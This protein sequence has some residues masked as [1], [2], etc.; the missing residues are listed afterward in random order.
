MVMT[1]SAGTI[2][3]VNTETER[4]FGYR[5]EELIGRAMDMLV[6]QRLR[7]EYLK[8]RAVF[9]VHPEARRVNANR[10]LFGLRRD[11]V[12]VP[13][14]VWLNPIHTSDGLYVLSVMVDIGER[15]RIDRLKDEFVSTVSHELR[16]PLTSIAGSLGLLVGGAAGTLPDAALR[17]L[18]IAQTNSHRLVRLINDILDIEKI[19]S[20]QVIF[21]FRRISTRALA[22]QAIEA[23]RAY[24]DGFAISIRLEPGSLAGEVLA[25]QDRLA[26][27]LTNLLS[28]AIKFSPRN[29]EVTIGTERRG[30][31]VRISV[32]DHGEGIPVKFRPHIFQKFAQAD[33]SDTRQKGGTG[34]GL[35]IVKEIVTRLGGSVGFEDAA[36]GGTV[37]FVELPAWE[38]IA[39]REIDADR[40]PD[41]VRILVCED[42][43]QAAQNLRDGLRPLGYSTDLAHNPA[44]AVTR[45]RSG[46]YAAIV[47]DF[48]LPD[49]NGL[50]LIRQLREQPESYK[51]PIVVMSAERSEQNDESSALHVVNWIAKPADAYELSDILDGAIARGL[52]GKPRVLHI[53]DEPDVLELVARTLEPNAR[54]VSVAS[55]EE[56]RCALA[57]Q[58]FDL[59]VLDITLGRINGLDLLPELRN[60]NGLKIPV[61]VFSGRSADSA[62]GPQ[63]EARLD[64]SGTAL[65]DLVA[66]VN[67][68]LM[69]K[70]S[71]SPL[72]VA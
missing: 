50:G 26:Q 24:A 51:T 41:A 61:I 5:R 18:T 52:Y 2:V 17:L 7:G 36:G 21:D 9:A 56:A 22:E 4:L 12:E 55:A 54:V 67:D 59:A 49:G 71:Q 11:N 16:T 64:K 70:S 35:S 13:I 27:V 33:A 40:T 63:V 31:R 37:F 69:L 20:G 47:V 25:D 32:R 30:D 66:A 29:G 1:D 58:D 28:N 23:N 14:E 42:N 10:E 39:A 62:A 3:L 60:R 44:D 57:M 53:D 48:E 19:E 43:P 38:Q 72:E 6:P 68:R 65:D 8:Q 45:A 46:C 34:L 15:K